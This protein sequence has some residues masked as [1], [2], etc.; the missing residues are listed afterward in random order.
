MR[1]LFAV[2]LA[3]ALSSCGYRVAGTSDLLPP[4]IRTVAIPA[5][6][7]STVRYKL[8]DLMPEAF[9]REFIAHSRYKVV[10]DPGRA[11]MVLEGAI[12]NYAYNPT[13]FD[14]A[15]Q[16]ANVADVRVTMRVK[17]TERSTGRVLFDRPS[18]EVKDSYQISRDPAEY[19]EES[20]PALRRASDRVAQQIVTAILETF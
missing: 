19:F 14:P 2:V 8:T 15:A 18:M 9:A 6:G 5:F 20:D 12:L 11:D 1:A 4:T 7:N 10:T 16:R 17:L 13:I 3:A